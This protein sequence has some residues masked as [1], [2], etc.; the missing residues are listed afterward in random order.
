MI[1]SI[2]TFR[3][4]NINFQKAAMDIEAGYKIWSYRVDAVHKDATQAVKDLIE[5][6]AALSQNEDDEDE[7]ADND[8]GAKDDKKRRKRKLQE[9]VYNDD[10]KISDK[11]LTEIKNPYLAVKAAKLDSATDISELKLSNAS[12]D[13]LTSGI[14]PN[15]DSNLIPVEEETADE[16]PCEWVDDLLG[17]ISNIATVSFV[18]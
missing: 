9:V 14:H 10:K 3:G 6:N 5:T 13:G 12:V 7:G 1:F 18:Y 11:K 2:F 4:G 15:E 16:I 17:E 8:E